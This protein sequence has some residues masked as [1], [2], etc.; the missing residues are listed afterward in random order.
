MAWTML[1]CPTVPQL[2]RQ[3]LD[4]RIAVRPVSDPGVE[5]MFS[6]NWLDANGNLRMSTDER[7][8]TP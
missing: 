6:R 1:K 7:L 4:P 3:Y 2:A 8:G 5:C